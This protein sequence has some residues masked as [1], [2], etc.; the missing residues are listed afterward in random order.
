[1]GEGLPVD[2]G[3]AKG[4]IGSTIAVFSQG[5]YAGARILLIL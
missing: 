5:R 4:Q 1:V 2:I 3:I